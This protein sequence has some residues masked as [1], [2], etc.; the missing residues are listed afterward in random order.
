MK[1]SATL[2]VTSFAWKKQRPNLYANSDE[3]PTGEVPRFRLTF[4]RERTGLD[5]NQAYGLYRTIRSDDRTNRRY[6]NMCIKNRVQTVDVE[7]VFENATEGRNII[8]VRSSRRS[9]GSGGSE[10]T[11]AAVLPRDK[12]L[13]RN[14]PPKARRRFYRVFVRPFTR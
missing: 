2:I 6:R 1:F 13:G 9:A 10:H 8:S 3:V 14:P 11:A 5:R 12:S 7:V 4:V